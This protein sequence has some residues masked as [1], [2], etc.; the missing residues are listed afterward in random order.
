MRG[1]IISCLLVCPLQCHRDTVRKHLIV[2]SIAGPKNN[3]AHLTL[4]SNTTVEDLFSQLF[5]AA[6]ASDNSV[7][8]LSRY[9]KS[10]TNVKESAIW[11]SIGQTPWSH[12]FSGFYHISPDFPFEA[13]ATAAELQEYTLVDRGTWFGVEP[14]VREHMQVFVRPVPSPSLSLS[15]SRCGDAN[16]GLRC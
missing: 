8:F 9:D 7:R 13:L 2:A 14:W 6:V 11:A 16:L 3:P 5:I 10:A 1:A 4:A 15:L 12:P